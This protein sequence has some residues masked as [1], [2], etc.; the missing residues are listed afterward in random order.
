MTTTKFRATDIVVDLETLGTS[1]NAF[2]TA[3][4]AVAFNRHTGVID[5]GGALDLSIDLASP[6]NGTLDTPTIKWWATQDNAAFREATQGTVDLR[7]A[8]RKFAL[9]YTT[10]HDGACVWGHGPTFDNVILR[11][12]FERNDIIWPA[13]FRLD[14]CVRTIAD[15]CTT[16]TDISPFDLVDFEG[17]RHVA[18]L[19]A[20]YEAQVILKAFDLMKEAPVV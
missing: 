16:A 7:S 3:I 6:G 13:S 8:L 11:N 4:G 5:R 1:N 17:T 19:D 20:I 14:R 18:V 15:V 9:W 12:A 10:L 2:I